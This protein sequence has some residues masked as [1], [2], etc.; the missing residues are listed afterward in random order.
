MSGWRYQT[1]LE[2]TNMLIRK[3][4]ALIYIMFNTTGIQLHAG[5]PDHITETAATAL[6]S[7]QISLQIKSYT[8]CETVLLNKHYQA[9]KSC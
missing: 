5:L 1:G 6:P 7:S 4:I 2:K 3:L 8:S 9:E